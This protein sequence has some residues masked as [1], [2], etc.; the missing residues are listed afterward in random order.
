VILARRLFAGA[1]LVVAVAPALLLAAGPVFD[2]V[3]RSPR[4]PRGMDVTRALV[5]AMRGPPVLLVP[6]WSDGGD[7]L[8]PLRGRLLAAGWPPDD[9]EI[10]EFEDPEG[11]NV[12]HAGELGTAV[13]RTLR[14]TG[15]PQVD[16]VAHSMGGLATRCYLL[17]GGASSVRRVVF[18]ATPHQGTMSAN[19]AWGEG[20]REME[21]GSAFLLDLIR[22]RPVPEG[23]RAITIRTPLDLHVVPN[24][25]ATLPGIPDVE[26]CCPT[27][28]GLLDDE[29]TF[30]AIE[31]F[32]AG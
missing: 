21:P 24:E 5:P 1:A 32:L 30:R 2:A 18:L 8:A 7:E 10:I 22:G 6:G 17:D 26:I 4:V 14:R 23:V 29:Q 3:E 20:A 19:L 31:R 28:A 16:I 9:V 15:Q 25:S 11:S 27:H 13:E 12:Q